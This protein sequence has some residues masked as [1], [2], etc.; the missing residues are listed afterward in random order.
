MSYQHLQDV[1]KHAGGDEA[2]LLL[3]AFAWLG[4]LAFTSPD[5]LPS[6][7]WAFH[8][9]ARLSAVGEKARPVACGDVLR[10]LFGG[11]YCR[12]HRN[13]LASL[14][15][16]G[17]QFGV[18]VAG[19]VEIVAAMAQLTRDGG[20]VLLG[21]DSSNAFNAVKRLEA[22]RQVANHVPDLYA[23]ASKV[24]G[25]NSNPLLLFGLDGEEAAE[26]VESRQGVQQGD[27]LGTLLFSLALHPILLDFGKCFSSLSLPSFL[28]DLT[29]LCL[30]AEPLSQRLARMAEAYN[31]LRERLGAVGLKVNESKSVCLLPARA[32]APTFGE[33]E[34]HDEMKGEERMEAEVR[35]RARVKEWACTILDVPMCLGPAEGAV[36]VG[37]PFGGEEFVQR[38]IRERLRD[39][40][41]Q[42]LLRELVLLSGEDAHLSYSL[43]RMCFLPL[44]TFLSRNVGPSV[45]EP[46]LMRFDG[47]VLGAC[48]GLLQEPSAVTEDVFIQ[49]GEEVRKLPDDWTQTVSQVYSAELPAVG[50][51]LREKEAA[52][53]NHVAFNGMQ[54]AQI[55]LSLSSGGLGLPSAIASGP[56]AFLAC[57][58]GTLQTAL[59]ALSPAHRVALC[60]AQ[61]GGS[62]ALLLDTS[63]LRHVG[64]AVVR[65]LA[66]GI[67]RQELEKVGCIPELVEWAGNEVGAGEALMR[68]LLPPSGNEEPAG[69]AQAL[70]LPQRG[71][72][73]QHAIS[74]ALEAHK[75]R[76]YQHLIEALPLAEERKAHQ[77]RHLSQSG[78]GSHAFFSAPMSSDPDYTLEATVFRE[79]GRR[80]LALDRQVEPGTLC[81]ACN[82]P[83]SAAHALRCVTTG[84]NTF[85]HHS[86]VRIFAAALTKAGL[87][88]VKKEDEAPF[89]PRGFNGKMDITFPG[90]QFPLPPTANTAPGLHA[91]ARAALLD[92]TLRDVTANSVIN[93]ASTTRGH[94]ASM[95]IAQKNRHYLGHFDS[96]TYT[97]F[98]ISL[99]SYGYLHP[100]SAALFRAL[101]LY[102]HNRSGGIWPVGR[103]MAR[104]RHLFSITLQRVLS[105]SLSRNLARSNGPAHVGAPERVVLV[106]GYLRVRL[107]TPRRA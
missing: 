79:A 50:A 99:E 102:Q 1:L 43:L 72:K 69:E 49:E 95:G 32:T 65:L 47:L 10:R 74:E 54:C 42:R 38:T 20:G 40:S 101:S 91:P 64:S 78:T 88:G 33:E 81:G 31:W 27:S 36:L 21:I 96:T 5:S 67:T 13:Q 41:S 25:A 92:F 63:Y 82:A 106:D 26:V 2:R 70:C 16:Q 48:A 94:A 85:R 75:R 76:E 55:R 89:V 61:E 18:G 107:L 103:C 93:Q 15:S 87:L 22:L 8:T 9:A 56:A 105:E 84:E 53:Q 28:D 73:Y 30:T 86:F 71:L 14:F 6:D 97:L 45:M 60:A 68:A 51:S 80:A 7:F 17:K 35:E 12:S 100:S 29:M 19:G 24:Y 57:T 4:S 11:A 83:Q 44:A 3:E 52:L 39:D 59:A 104:W 37:V 98:T 23:Y 58:M 62:T 77:A 34:G 90:H 46:E 66:E